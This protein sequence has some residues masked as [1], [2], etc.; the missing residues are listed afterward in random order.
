MQ[1]KEERER[2][3]TFVGVRRESH[4]SNAQFGKSESMV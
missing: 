2:E 1:R 4:E 3:E